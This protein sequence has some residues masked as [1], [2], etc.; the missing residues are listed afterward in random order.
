MKR[1]T[2]KTRNMTNEQT[3]G[4]R[5]INQFSHAGGLRAGQ[6]GQASSA[7]PNQSLLP[8]TPGSARK[9]PPPNGLM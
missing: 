4:Q 6:T 5:R 3:G 8:V 1:L 7:R 9:Y 2:C